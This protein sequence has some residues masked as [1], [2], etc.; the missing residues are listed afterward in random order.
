M[1]LVATMVFVVAVVIVWRKFNK[2]KDDDD[3]DDIDK[4]GFV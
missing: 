3:F 4:M 1:K 2:R